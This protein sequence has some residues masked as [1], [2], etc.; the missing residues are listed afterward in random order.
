MPSKAPEYDAGTL[1]HKSCRRT[2]MR[3]HKLVQDF[4]CK[5][6]RDIVVFFSPKAII[7]R[8]IPLRSMIH[9]R[10]AAPSRLS[11]SVDPFRELHP[12]A[13]KSGGIATSVPRGS[14]KHGVVMC[15]EHLRDVPAQPLLSFV[16]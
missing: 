8:S 9:R 2:V 10:S 4:V 1:R 13:T 6:K 7:A 16:A 5:W 14:P 11:L 3:G 15:E 12:R